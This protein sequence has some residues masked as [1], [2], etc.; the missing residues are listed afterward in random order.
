MKK[1]KTRVKG[2]LIVKIAKLRKENNLL[3]Q[4]LKEVKP[5]EKKYIGKINLL[6]SELRKVKLE[7]E[8]L[9]SKKE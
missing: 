6:K 5:K 1:L 3:K 8:K 9:N 4:Q 2:W 7:N